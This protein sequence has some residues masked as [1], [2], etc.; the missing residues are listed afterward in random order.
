MIKSN[1]G[2][3]FLAVNVRT[4]IS[5][6]GLDNEDMRLFRIL[7][8]QDKAGNKCQR[9]C[10]EEEEEVFCFMSVGFKSSIHVSTNFN[11]MGRM[12]NNYSR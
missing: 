5:Y 8:F 1:E 12:L 7:C 3:R 11:I 10:G 2:V 9:R 6:P 4:C